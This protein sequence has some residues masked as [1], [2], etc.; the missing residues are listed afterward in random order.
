M[1][2]NLRSVQQPIVDPAP[3]EEVDQINPQGGNG[4]GEGSSNTFNRAIQVP[5][6]GD[7]NDDNNLSNELDA[8]IKA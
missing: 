3:E 8:M 5:P 2:R 7:P 4:N 1:S 6:K